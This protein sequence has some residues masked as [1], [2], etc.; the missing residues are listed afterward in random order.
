LPDSSVLASTIQS[1]AAAKTQTLSEKDFMDQIQDSG[2]LQGYEHSARG[3]R[4]N[5]LESVRLF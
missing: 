4:I 3:R 5:Q 1:E 2:T